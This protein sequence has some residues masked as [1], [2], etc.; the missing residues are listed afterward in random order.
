M[1]RDGGSQLALT[2][3][4]SPKKRK[5]HLQ[6]SDL[7]IQE[8]LSNDP[9]P[10]FVVDI[11]CDATNL[12]TAILYQNSAFATAPG[13]E[14]GACADLQR[15]CLLPSDVTGKAADDHLICCGYIWTAITLH[16]RWRVISGSGYGNAGRV[17]SSK[18]PTKLNPENIDAVPA[19]QVWQAKSVVSRV[20][21]QSLSIASPI[22]S[23]S[24]L[25][26]HDWTSAPPNIQFSPYVQFL[27]AWDW[28][29]T[30][31]GPLE[32]WSPELRVLANLITIDP[33]PAVFF[34]G[35]EYAMP[36]LTFVCKTNSCRLVGIYNEP[37][38]VYV[39]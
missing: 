34:W 13:L 16:E 8:L 10:S 29:K 30:P 15:W 27:R 11:E 6:W 12:S 39:W 5:S 24:V 36:P 19:R 37:Y 25:P 23:P 7:S 4:T 22:S 20:E 14:R 26:F 2:P 32:S 9:R 33:S 17:H 18:E 3:S 31:L 35:P 28:S 21:S 38:I 1:S